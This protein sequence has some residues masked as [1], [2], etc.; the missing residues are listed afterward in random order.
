MYPQ[1]MAS[2]SILQEREREREEGKKEEKYLNAD[3]LTF[4]LHS[5][6]FGEHE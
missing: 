1:A 6:H 3:W 2:C 4:E 5:S